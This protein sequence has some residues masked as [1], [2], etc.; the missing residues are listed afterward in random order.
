MTSWCS[1]AFTGSPSRWW[2][3][4]SRSLCTYV[5][6]TTGT[7]PSEDGGG[8]AGARRPRPGGRG[9]GQRLDRDGGSLLAVLIPGRRGPS[10]DPEESGVPAGVGRPTVPSDTPPTIEAGG[11]TSGT[12]PRQRGTSFRHRRKEPR[13]S[14]PPPTPSISSPPTAAARPAPPAEAHRAMYDPGRAGGPAAS[15]GPYSA[16]R[17]P[18]LAT[19]STPRSC[20]PGRRELTRRSC[21]EDSRRRRWI[22]RRRRRRAAAVGGALRSSAARWGRRRRAAV[23]PRRWGGAGRPLSAGGEAVAPPHGVSG[24][25]GSAVHRLVPT[26]RARDCTIRRKE[27]AT[28]A[29]AARWYRPIEPSMP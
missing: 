21:W 24:R 12:P 10:G 3:Y 25:P 1:W 26:G 27:P 19:G 16:C 14:R 29:R 23:V 11:N 8:V 15:A 5:I 4:P 17:C 22:S 6:P 18:E 7:S 9:R 28:A 2:L 13:C 20:V